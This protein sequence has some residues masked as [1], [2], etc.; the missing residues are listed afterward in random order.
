[1]TASYLPAF[2]VTPIAAVTLGWAAVFLHER[3]LRSERQHH[4]GE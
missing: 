1:M 4:P 2:V 3:S